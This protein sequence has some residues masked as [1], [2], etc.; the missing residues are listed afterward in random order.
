MKKKKDHQNCENLR[1]R[2]AARY[3]PISRLKSWLCVCVCEE[4]KS[5]HKSCG[6]SRRIFYHGRYA[7]LYSRAYSSERYP[8]LQ[9][10]CVCVC[11]G[12]NL[13]RKKI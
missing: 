7:A 1:A 11:I 8:S 9:R 2:E 6:L 12:K 3:L 5:R 4:K 10:T 13:E